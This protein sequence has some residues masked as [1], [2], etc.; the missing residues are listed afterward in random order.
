MSMIPCDRECT[1]QS[2]GYCCLEG[3]ISPPKDAVT[4]EAGCLYFAA[5]ECKRGP[6][7][8]PEAPPTL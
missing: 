6:R 3:I 8:Q 4:T 5:R 7:K 1:N 2:D